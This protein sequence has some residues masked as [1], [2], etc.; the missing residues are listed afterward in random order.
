MYDDREIEEAMRSLSTTDGSKYQSSGTDSA[1]IELCSLLSIDT[2]HLHVANEMRRLF[3]RAAFDADRE[4]RAE[5]RSRNARQDQDQLSL[6]EAVAGRN[7][8]SGA[9]LPAIL[10]RK[11][12]F[13]DGREDWPKATGNGLGMVIDE[14][15]SNG[16]VVY[17]FTHNT[18][19]K[20]TQA[21]FSHCVG[22][23]DPATMVTL[24]RLNPYHIS[25][26]LQVAE[27]AKSERDHSTA[28]E[29]IERALFAFGR[30]VHSSFANTMAQGKARLDFRRPENREFWLACWRYIGN[31][32]MRATWRTALEWARLLLSLDPEN[33]PYCICLSI[34]RLA[35]RAQQAQI[36]LD[37]AGSQFFQDRWNTLVN[38]A[39]SVGLA[40]RV[41]GNKEKGRELLS[42]AIQHFPWVA[43]RI[44][45]QLD[46]GN[47]PPSTWGKAATTDNDAL[48][49]EI[50]AQLGPMD[51]W[52]RPEYAAFLK[53][54]ATDVSTTHD[55]ESTIS[56]D[57]RIA[58]FVIL[59]DLPTLIGHLP[60]TLTADIGS[61]SDPVPPEA[62]ILEYEIPGMQRGLQEEGI[63][64]MV[65]D[66]P[67]EFIRL[68]YMFTRLFSMLE[69]VGEN[70]SMSETGSFNAS[71]FLDAT[72]DRLVEL[73]QRA[74]LPLTEIRDWVRRL[75]NFVDIV[76]AQPSQMV[77]STEGDVVQIEDGN[78]TFTLMSIPEIASAQRAELEGE[79]SSDVVEDAQ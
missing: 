56:I 79:G 40:E 17:R 13:M 44:F 63:A 71:H 16:I 6:S 33:D 19:Y 76:E 53:N 34:D 69:E 4:E 68:G 47:L 43:S 65:V 49:A 29:L 73:G 8:R 48:H 54:T 45:Q 23:M 59:A 74:Q 7:S 67:R 27:I 26:L 77:R 72:D 10:R 21:E 38:I 36:F 70:S 22:L 12:I 66:R 31:I 3:G 42:K 64:N 1:E 24:L 78:I 35:L 25:T 30:T 51:L 5:A 32:S 39:Y 11:N 60:R 50:Y 18:A 28:G 9:G 58:R 2:A 41:L 61:M 46:L 37:L 14:T 75:R 52:K 20:Q 57:R 55:V 62:Q 15:K